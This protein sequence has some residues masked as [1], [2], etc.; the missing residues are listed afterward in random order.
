MECPSC[1]GKV[2]VHDW[3]CPFCEHI[4]DPS[5][6]NLEQSGE[7]DASPIR[8]ERTRIVAWDPR[9]EE[10]A[11]EAP[12]AMILGEVDVSAKDFS[13]VQ[14]PSA[15][16]G[17]RMS[18][19]LFYTSGV[20]SRILH[21]EAVPALTKK[22]SVTPHTPYE[23]FILSC[24]DGKRSVREIQ[25]ASGLAPQ[26]VVITLL[27]L[28]DK[29]AIRVETV[30]GAAPK[31]NTGD[32]EQTDD[33][34]IPEPLSKQIEDL[35][36]VTD[37]E[38][39]SD[40]ES[41]LEGTVEGDA[42]ADELPVENNKDDD[43][44]ELLQTHDLARTHDQNFGANIDEDEDES[45]IPVVKPSELDEGDSEMIT[46]HTM[47]PMPSMPAVA[48][49]MPSLSELRTE[50]DREQ[51]KVPDLRRV[52]LPP[53]PPPAEKLPALEEE[54][55]EEDSDPTP[56]PRVQAAPVAATP[57]P[58]VAPTPPPL[59]DMEFLVEVPKSERKVAP[60]PQPAP[61]AKRAPIEERDRRKGGLPAPARP[62]PA[63]P[64]AE[65][66]DLPAPKLAPLPVA[67]REEPAPLKIPEPEPVKPA[68]PEPA[69][70]PAAKADP[71]KKPTIDK[72]L[73]P[74]DGVR[75]AKA[76]K[77]F[78]EALKDKAEGNLVSAR[79]NMKL[80]LTF[81]PSNELYVQAFD[82]LSKGAGANATPSKMKSRARELYDQATRAEELGEVDQAIE[83]LEKALQE[84][85]E[86]MY[87]NRLGVLLAMKKK[88]FLR[89]QELIE[90]AL[91]IAP[92]NQ[93][94]QHN[95]GKVLS[96]AAAYEVDD[97]HSGGKKGGILGFLG[98]KK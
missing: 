72:K 63:T 28:L 15:G 81:D 73:T 77:L 22:E 93:T 47:L 89:A 78:E 24:I 50:E 80:A 21:P 42:F 34:Y 13:V 38:E 1:S 31:E 33:G 32:V 85:K 86:A 37:F 92:G 44:N 79:M 98:R 18:T 39:V 58:R 90:T 41:E 71:A 2:D 25:R 91:K 87:Y 4:L 46:D 59:L 7:S 19:F 96:M 17:G 69:P 35:P 36:S 53:P 88:Q 74:V 66:V 49:M 45:N 52:S 95:L 82:E 16:G 70:A 64:S 5:V 55:E 14:G 3:L 84:A 6:L 23:D 57:L 75:M 29:G 67:K 9:P 30:G 43:N 26:E 56:P 76:A 65:K 54:E 11:P 68:T 40:E 27:T 8:A 20:T 10:P 48:P 83:L 12:E 97:R 94:Y 62:A 51:R 61:A 60:A